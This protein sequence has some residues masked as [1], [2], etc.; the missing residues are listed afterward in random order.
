MYVVRRRCRITPCT[1]TVHGLNTMF[2]HSYPCICFIETPGIKR[3]TW[4]THCLLLLF[5]LSLSPA[6]FGGKGGKFSL[7]QYFDLQNEGKIRY[8]RRGKRRE[9][10]KG[11]MT[12][13]QKFYPYLNKK[14]A[15]DIVVLWIQDQNGLEL[16]SQDCWYITQTVLI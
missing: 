16:S 8:K 11:N 3:N 14:E 6:S 15:E 12:M 7:F 10:C 4:L 1:C 5:S 9:C 13:L 2:S